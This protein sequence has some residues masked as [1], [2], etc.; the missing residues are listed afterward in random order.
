MQLNKNLILEIYDFKQVLKTILGKIIDQ[1]VFIGVGRLLFMNFLTY[2]FKSFR[3]CQ[4]KY[5]LLVS[6]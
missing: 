2:I 3:F 6:N 4:K 5:Y 1:Y